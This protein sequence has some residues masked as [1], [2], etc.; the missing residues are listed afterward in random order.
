MT[1]VQL[2]ESVTFTC[3]LPLDEFGSDVRW[4]KQSVGDHLKLI[5]A[6]KNNNKPEYGP[7]FSDSRLDLIVEK[8]I[9]KLTIFSTSEEDDGMY[10][11]AVFYWN[12]NFWSG[13]Y[14]SLKGKY[15]ICFFT[16]FWSHFNHFQLHCVNVL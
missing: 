8:N 6:V 13:T 15:V 4:Y 16:M 9:S 2:G 1:T 11:C 3:V 14:L 7:E 10:H 5:V 12:K